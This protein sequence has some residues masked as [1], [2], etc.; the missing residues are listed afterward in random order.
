MDDSRIVKRIHKWS[1][2]K[3]K[4]WE[5]RMLEFIDH[6][7]LSNYML[8]DRPHKTTCLLKAKETLHEKEKEKWYESL[9]DDRK[10]EINGNKRTYR[11]YKNIFK[12]ETYVTL[13]MSRKQ[14]KILAKFRCGNLPLAIESGTYT[15]PKTPLN[16]RLC[17]YCTNNVIEDET[18]FLIKCDFYDD[19]RSNLFT[20]AAQLN[21]IFYTYRER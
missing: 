5:K 10:N 13:N 8:I 4:S 15:K 3:G 11:Q 14:R 9:M 1:F 12:L 7:N 21:N 6:N 18:H 16:E 20:E 17:I 19:I 2:N